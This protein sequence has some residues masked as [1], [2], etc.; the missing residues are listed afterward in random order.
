M[1]VSPCGS[2]TE[3]PVWDFTTCG[4]PPAVASG[5]SPANG[6]TDVPIN[7]DLDWDDAV[8]ATIYGVYFG[9]SGQYVGN[10]PASQ[11]PLVGNFMRCSA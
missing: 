3:G 7:T 10:T 2:T 9:T 1:T 6:A 8:G 5:P 4:N 11:F